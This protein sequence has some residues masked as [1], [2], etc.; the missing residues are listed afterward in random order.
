MLNSAPGRVRDLEYTK[1]GGLVRSH[2]RYME[3]IRPRE[4]SLSKDGESHEN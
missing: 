1:E 2:G 3:D 4:N